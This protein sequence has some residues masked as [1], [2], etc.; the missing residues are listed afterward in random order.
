M[1]VILE[2][3]RCDPAHA[4]TG[5]A[6]EGILRIG[7]PFRAGRTVPRPGDVIRLEDMDLTALRVI[8]DWD[9]PD[10][11]VTVMVYP[12][13]PIDNREDLYWELFTGME[14]RRAEKLPARI[15]WVA[16]EW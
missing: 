10:G 9:D 7:V 5:D 3:L 8:H 4:D 1:H 14:S 15:S 16:K 6:L 11:A 12:E 13:L 2:L